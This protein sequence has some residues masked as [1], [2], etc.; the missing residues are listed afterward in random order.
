MEQQQKMVRVSVDV[1]SGA[2]RFH[3]GVQA[4][5]IRTALSM[6]RGR[7]PGGEV[8]VAFPIEPEGFFVQEPSALARIVGPEQTQREA[9]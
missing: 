2:A 4:Q 9:A 3:V 7:Y 5:S 8:R 6:V 1:R